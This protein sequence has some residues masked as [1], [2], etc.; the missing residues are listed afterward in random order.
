MVGHQV[1]RM[2]VLYQF[3]GICIFYFRS[4]DLAVVGGGY[5]TEGGDYVEKVR[6]LGETI[7]T[8]STIVAKH[9][10]PIRNGVVKTRYCY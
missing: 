8:A 3:P 9:V 5:L 1:V 4:P 6:R 10:L 7:G 2:S